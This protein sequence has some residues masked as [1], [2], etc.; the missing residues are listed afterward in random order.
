MGDINVK[1]ELE[2]ER[3]F[4]QGIDNISAGIKVNRSEM[5][6]LDA[7][8]G[9]NDQSVEGLTAK[10]DVLSRT[11]A[12]QSDKVKALQYQMVKYANK[13]GEADK[14]TLKATQS[15]NE[16]CAEL[17]ALNAEL[18]RNEAALQSAASDTKRY[19]DV[20]SELEKQMRLI[21]SEIQ[22]ANS[23]YDEESD[24]VG[25][26]EAKQSALNKA[27]KTQEEIVT[28]I[29][30]A[31]SAAAK[32]YG[33]TS[34]EVY[35]LSLKLNEAQAEFG[36]LNS[37]FKNCETEINRNKAQLREAESYTQKY[38]N[39]VNSADRGIQELSSELKF[40][41]SE[42]SSNVYSAKTFSD[43]C[44]NLGKTIDFQ[45]QKVAD[46]KAAMEMAETEF[47]QNSDKAH[48]LKIAYNDARAELA[49][50]TSELHKNEE[51]L[52]KAAS[53]SQKYKSSVTEVDK[54]LAV[55]G[56]RLR[57]TD[58]SIAKNAKSVEN[59]KNKHQLLAQEIALQATKVTRLRQAME[60]A[61][62]EYGKNS[63]EA[64]EL[65][66][67]YNDARAALT[68]FTGEIEKNNNAI[69]NIQIEKCQHQ[70]EAYEKK[71]K[72]IGNSMKAAGDSMTKYLT[73]PIVAGFALVT[74]GSEEFRGDLSKL[75]NNARLA[76]VE[77][78]DLHDK[79]GFLN[80][81]TGETDSN[82]EALSNLM[83]AGFKGNNLAE[84]MELLSG[85]V[86]KFPDTLKIESLADS[87]QETLATGEATG[88][89]AELLGRLGI[90]TDKFTEGLKR[91]A[92]QGKETKY[93][94]DEL[95]KSGLSDVTKTFEKNNKALIESQKAAYEMQVA[96]AKVGNRLMPIMTKITNGITSILDA[97]NGLDRGTQNFILTAAAVAGAV[98]PVLS[99]TGNLAL[100]IGALS[101]A[102]GKGALS[103]TANAA[104]VSA[105]GVATAGAGASAAAAA[106]GV[107]AFNL[108]LS[109]CPALMI[110]GGL[111][112]V[113]AAIAAIVISAQEA[114]PELRKLGEE[115]KDQQET[116]EKLAEE[117]NEAI[118]GS[119]GEAEHLQALKSELESYLDENDKVID[120][121]GRVKYIVDE[122]NKAMP[123]SIKWIDSET[124][125]YQKTEKAID[126]L[127]A[128]K[129]AQI[130]LDAMGPE[131][132]NAILNVKK[133]Q[134]EQAALGVEISKK[135]Q[136]LN[137]ITA[138]QEGEAGQAR[139]KQI[140]D[141]QGEI[142]SLASQWIEALDSVASGSGTLGDAN[143]LQRQ[144]EEK[145]ADLKELQNLQ[146][147]QGDQARQLVND[148]NKLSERQKE[149]D[150]V[151]DGYLRTIKNFET[152]TEAVVTS[153]TNL[154][155]RWADSYIKA[156][157]TVRVSA[158]DSMT[159][160]E[161]EIKIV[162]KNYEDGLITKEALDAAERDFANL[163]KQCENFSA[164]G[165]ESVGEQFSSGVAVG[166]TNN[167]KV[168]ENAAVGV[169]NA[170]ISASQRAADIH[171]PSRV[172]ANKVGKYLPLGIAQ[173]YKE[174][175]PTALQQMQ[176]SFSR[177][178]ATMQAIAVNHSNASRPAVQVVGG[179]IDG[180]YIGTLNIYPDAK[181]WGQVMRIVEQAERARHDQRRR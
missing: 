45:T 130:I 147:Q 175:M 57:A 32:E 170:A 59:Y 70:L 126:A 95:S 60:A 152:G 25:N 10:N 112:A 111:L 46:L 38:L 159:F 14:Q 80:A 56:S 11:I 93:A 64:R 82:I 149:C 34:D 113:G 177:I 128:K 174:S 115:L 21:K 158:E 143:A 162:R 31:V 16:A 2:G 94:L 23:A 97:F 148:I 79:M 44:E 86:L 140:Q 123:D 18:K 41:D 52:K 105:A 160:A 85:A 4:K 61:G 53:E 146:E 142:S 131:Y 35:S 124:L 119:I 145:K 33:E 77:M 171:S 58:A 65:E 151:Q 40:L 153:N 88:Q 154:M 117:R 67:A 108:S 19:A 39:A 6:L 37:A 63:N 81:I 120:S 150:N 138:E 73:A 78:Q 7:Q 136:E 180:A 125:A 24:C 30:K 91:A 66:I 76:G 1:V 87:L 48:E 89:F 137:K 179:G 163:K 13:Y 172:F 100:G 161:E 168:V 84:A 129:R 109:A 27:I 141:L 20:T 169:V 8:Y 114:N 167:T 69:K 98:G 121:K 26:L 15:Y 122:I 5:K 96:F 43:K 42:I 50:L 176:D 135:Q 165:G 173:G 104:A 28:Q 49:A 156:H 68:K 134:N 106:G 107:R 72:S 3:E 144:I 133:V 110:V 101:M 181:Q 178:T 166:M 51:E 164:D 36:R 54:K 127:I 22:M 157:T 74:K 132:E 29:G 71:M 102:F 9:K 90:E 103:A 55:L 139:I 17:E 92:K 83:Q 47:G 155:N 12:S 99:V 118:Q 116:M 62:K 75:E